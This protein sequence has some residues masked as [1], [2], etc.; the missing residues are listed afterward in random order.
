MLAGQFHKQ[1]PNICPRSTCFEIVGNALRNIDVHGWSFESKLEYRVAEAEGSR[2]PILRTIH[3]QAIGAFDV[4][5][6]CVPEGS[7]SQPQSA[8][9]NTVLPAVYLLLRK[10]QKVKMMSSFKAR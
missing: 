9:L 10:R 6:S 8:C 1:P 5:F 3:M 2:L 7:L 4:F